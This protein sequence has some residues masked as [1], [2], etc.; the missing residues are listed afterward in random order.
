MEMCKLSYEFFVEEESKYWFS[1]FDHNGLYCRDIETQEISFLGIIPG[2]LEYQFRLYSSIFKV[3]Q[4]IIL[5]PHN[6]SGIAV[7][8]IGYKK[9]SKINLKA[10]SEFGEYKIAM[11]QH[12]FW[13]ATLYNN[14]IF[15]MPCNYPAMVILNV[16]TSQLIYITDFVKK[17]DKNCLINQPY[18]TQIK[19]ENEMAYCSCGCINAIVQINLQTYASEIIIV[20]SSSDGYCGII[21]LSDDF[22][23]APVMSGGVV[24][25]C[26]ETN[27][28]VEYND[29]PNGFECPAVPFQKIYRYNNSLLLLPALANQFVLLNIKTGKMQKIEI[30]SDII[31]RE[32]NK[33]VYSYDRATAYSYHNN[34]L[35]FVS[36]TDYGI[37]RYDLEKGKLTSGFLYT[38]YQYPEKQNLYYL[39]KYFNMERI[40]FEESDSYHLK[41][42]VKCIE[43]SLLKYSIIKIQR[44]RVGEKIYEYLK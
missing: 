27:K 26:S 37:Y 9:F 1:A 21:K 23:L 10:V 13:V 28:V 44:D 25:Y 11:E 15:M 35:S 19:V 39:G 38:N 3:G 36:G 41:D 14:E 4:K 22:W 34:I 17:L 29:Y 16:E 33:N 18:I 42:F 2:E 30:I 32:K 24:K 40:F 5:V 12:K 31:S 8:D 7:Y 6:A 43:L 20:P